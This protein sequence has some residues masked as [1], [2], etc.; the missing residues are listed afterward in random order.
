MI[1][2]T[3]KYIDYPS[4]R[5]NATWCKRC[6]ICV[7]AC[8]Q[9]ALEI[10]SEGVVEIEGLCIRCGLCERQCPDLAIEVIGQPLQE[11]KNEKTA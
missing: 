1:K 9:H 6:F 4:V 8:P 11:Q 5:W 10:T 3:I 2:T 7:E